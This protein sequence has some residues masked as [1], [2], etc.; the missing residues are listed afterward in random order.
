MADLAKHI[1]P[2]NCI[3]CTLCYSYIVIIFRFVRGIIE[4]II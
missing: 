3:N 4:G 2:N 1:L